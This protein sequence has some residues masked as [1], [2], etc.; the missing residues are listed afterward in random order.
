[1]LTVA[2]YWVLSLLGLGIPWIWLLGALCLVGY[3]LEILSGKPKLQL[4]GV[5]VN[6]TKCTRSC[7]SCVKNCPYNIDVPSFRGK[8]N[9]VDCMLCGE[10]LAS[11]PTR[12]LSIGVKSGPSPKASRFTRF[13]PAIIAVV[14]VAAAYIVGGRFELPTIDEKWGITED[15]QIETVTLEGLKSVKCFSSSKAFKA[16]MENV[17]GVHG[18]KTYVGSHRVV[19]SF[20]PSRTSAEKIQQE[21]FVPSTFRVSS[22]DPALYPQVKRLTLRTEGMYD[23]MDLNYLGLY[24]DALFM[25]GKKAD[26]LEIYHSILSREPDN[27]KAQTSMRAYYKMEKNAAA[28]DSTTMLL[29]LNKNTN[30]DARIY[31]MRQEIAESESAG[32]DS[33]QIL[34]F[35]DAMMQSPD[36][37]ANVAI[38]YASYMSLKKM[39]QQG[40][41]RVLDKVLA[42]EPDNAAARLQ[43]VA[44][45]WQRDDLDR[46]VS[47]CKAARQYNPDEM[48]FYYYEGM[49]HFRLDDSDNALDA[50]QNGIGVIN[51]G[52]DPDIVS[53]FYAALGD[54]LFEKGRKAEA[55]AAYDSCLQ[56]KDDNLGCLNNYAY[57][58]CLSGDSLDKA[59]VMSLK[60]VMAEP[61]NSTYLDTYAWILFMQERYAEAKIYIDQ[62]VM[63]DTD[64]SAVIIE[65]AGDI[66][67]K[68]G[69]TDGALRLWRRAA[70][71]DPD[72]ALLKRKIRLKKYV[73]E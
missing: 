68:A 23:R 64:S 7:R 39:P 4:L 35:F 61:K 32:G 24:G 19:V 8:V 6:E 72:N 70:A 44:Y 27:S 54:L 42:M 55:F 59:A 49:A 17:P 5:I 15:M 18:V 26:A 1:M 14:L 57:Y 71:K 69:D 43:L 29:L 33:T 16:K 45:A 2:V 11:C 13:L 20:D 48:A 58:L 41:E 9:A 47:L 63:N 30:D 50:L 51:D 31:I 65:H 67:F 36:V 37:G 10:C 73:E 34:R 22:P 38:L 21:A 52:S 53:D 28:A 60:T 25:N 62:A 56:W 40:I 3:L 46:V 66:Y 12:A